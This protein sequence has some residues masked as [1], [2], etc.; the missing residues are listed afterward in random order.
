M[1]KP[2]DVIASLEDLAPLRL[3]ADWDNVGLLVATKR[4]VIHRVMTCLTLTIDV[5][6][7]AV[8]QKADLVVT[9]HPL[10][11][12]PVNRITEETPTGAI[13]VELVTAG[14]GV[15]SGHTAWDSAAYGINAMLAESLSLQDAAP[16]EPDERDPSVGFGRMGTASSHDTVDSV[17]QRLI[18]TLGCPGCSVAGDPSRPA[19]RIGIVCGSGGESVPIAAAAGCQTLVTGE[20]KLHDALEALAHNMAVIAVGHHLSEWFAM[21]RMAEKLS[22]ALP[23]LHCWASAV[24]QDPLCWV[25]NK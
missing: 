1:T 5:A 22:T 3:A 15:W 2:A 7:E 17:T 8:S 16:L 6:R 21:E 11:F 18:S 13:L 12:R 23:G 20:I 14:I 19:G 25:P 9:H 24:E 10:P 4:P